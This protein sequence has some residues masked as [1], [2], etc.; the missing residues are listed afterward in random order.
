MQV[1][2]QQGAGRGRDNRKAS[3]LSSKANSVQPQ[4][5]CATR[6][7]DLAQ[8]NE[9]AAA[10]AAYRLTAQRKMDLD[11]CTCRSTDTTHSVDQSQ[12]DVDS[13]HPEACETLQS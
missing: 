3:C 8:H 6:S 9:T 7:A 10:P 4:V 5:D 2:L 13:G 11:C 1:L 12:Q